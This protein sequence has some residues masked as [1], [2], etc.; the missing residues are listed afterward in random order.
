MSFYVK[1]KH[2]VCQMNYDDEWTFNFFGFELYYSLFYILMIN[3][4]YRVDRALFNFLS[5]S[6]ELL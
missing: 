5:N 1:V 2:A 4:N 6:F 3:G